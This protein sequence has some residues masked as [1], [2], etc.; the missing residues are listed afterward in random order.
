MFVGAASDKPSKQQAQAIVDILNALDWDDG[1]TRPSKS[2][3]PDALWLSTPSTDRAVIYQELL[4][5][6]QTDQEIRI[7]FDK[8]REA[9]PHFGLPCKSKPGNPEHRYQVHSKSPFRVRC[10]SLDCGSKLQRT[11]LVHW[12]AE[13]VQGAVLSADVLEG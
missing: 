11:A 12:I 13:L 8:A 5:R 2:L 4:E 3:D 9:G 1:I 10:A 7:L 6:H